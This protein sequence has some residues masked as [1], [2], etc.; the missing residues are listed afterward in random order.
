LAH[1]AASFDAFYSLVT[2]LAT[3]PHPYVHARKEVCIASPRNYLMNCINFRTVSIAFGFSEPC[4]GFVVS[5]GDFTNQT[6]A[7]M[8]SL[9]FCGHQNSAAKARHR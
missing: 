1:S 3:S 5:F 4:P 6:Q 9:F 2:A 8:L 7:E